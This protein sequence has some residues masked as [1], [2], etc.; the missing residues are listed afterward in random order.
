[1]Q[2]RSDLMT[3]SIKKSK[4]D[5]NV[6]KV[7]HKGE[8]KKVTHENRRKLHSKSIRLMHSFLCKEMAFL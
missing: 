6:F 7:I 2:C 3:T 8:W 1:M 5:G 4:S